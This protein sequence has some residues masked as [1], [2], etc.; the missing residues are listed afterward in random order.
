ME[1][2]PNHSVTQELREYSA[3]IAQAP[4]ESAY[5]PDPEERLRGPRAIG[6]ALVCCL[7][8]V[9]LMVAAVGRLRG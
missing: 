7:V 2:N 4:I 8:G 1:L 9:A 6:W 5:Q 3:A